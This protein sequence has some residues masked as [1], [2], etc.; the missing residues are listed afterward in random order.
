MNIADNLNY[1]S[2]TFEYNG[3]TWK[4]TFGSNATASI[5]DT[6]FFHLEPVLSSASKRIISGKI[7]ACD[8]ALHGENEST[9]SRRYTV[10][11]PPLSSDSR[12]GFSSFIDRETL[13]KFL[14]SD[15]S[16]MKD[17]FK[18]ITSVSFTVADI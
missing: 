17:N 9:F 4:L 1:E 3:T 11:P 10:G 18:I 8:F 14:T 7:I 15:N 6:F 5:I 13:G 16:S 12:Y 2:P